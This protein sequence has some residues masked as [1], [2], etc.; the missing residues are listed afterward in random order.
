[1]A[2]GVLSVIV[3]GDIAED[4]NHAIQHVRR[5]K[6]LLFVNKKKQ[7]NFILLPITT[8]SPTWHGK[9]N[10][11]FFASFLFTKKKT[12]PAC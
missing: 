4:V 11:V 1:V 6:G 10:E 5:K 2:V 7:K 8:A 9:M 3:E 12:L